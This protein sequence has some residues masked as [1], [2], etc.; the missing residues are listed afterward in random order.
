[1]SDLKPCPYDIRRLLPQ[2]PPMLLVDEVIG[3]NDERIVA[4]VTV[5]A[6]SLFLDDKGM[7]AHIAIEW[8]A[9][10]CGALVGIKAIEAGQPVRI[11]FLLGTRDFRSRVSRFQVGD[12]IA[13]AAD[14]VF[15]DGQMAVFDCSVARDA[16]VYA[17]A[18]LNVFQPGDLEAMLKEQG[19]VIQKNSVRS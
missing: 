12:R 14:S 3:W 7:P 17:T 19:V 18:R 5:R 9:Q 6:D 4:G 8:M 10:T 13:I 11:G 2:E 16:E 15:N 1:M